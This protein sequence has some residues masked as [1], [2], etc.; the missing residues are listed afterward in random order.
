MPCPHGCLDVLSA[1]RLGE[2]DAACGHK[3]LPC[4][5]GCAHTVRRKDMAAHCAGLCDARRV[6][7]PFAH[8]GCKEPVRARSGVLAQSACSC[9]C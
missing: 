3:P 4:A 7:C 8:L 1:G 2:H 5:Q 6:E 9:F